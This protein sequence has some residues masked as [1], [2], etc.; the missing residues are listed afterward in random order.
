MNGIGENNLARMMYC[1]LMKVE[2]SVSKEE[3]DLEFGSEGW[4]DYSQQFDILFFLKIL[5]TMGNFFS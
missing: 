1:K 5:K 4:G 3:H 2:Y